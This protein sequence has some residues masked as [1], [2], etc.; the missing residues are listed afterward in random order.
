MRRYPVKWYYAPDQYI[1]VPSEPWWKFLPQSSP[2]SGYISPNT[3]PSCA[4]EPP[5]G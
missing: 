1:Y 2:F 5:E 3:R 4:S